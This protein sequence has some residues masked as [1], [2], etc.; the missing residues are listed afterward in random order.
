MAVDVRCFGSPKADSEGVRRVNRQGGTSVA[1]KGVAE[2]G[3]S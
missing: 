2:A 3:G 1:A